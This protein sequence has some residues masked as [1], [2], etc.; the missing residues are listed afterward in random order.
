MKLLVRFEYPPADYVFSNLRDDISFG[1]FKQEVA[2]RK[3]ELDFGA[4]VG[5]GLG[6]DVIDLSECEDDTTLAEA[7]IKS[8]DTVVFFA[9]PGTKPEVSKPEARVKGKEKEESGDPDDEFKGISSS[10]IFP[11]LRA[12]LGHKKKRELA[13]LDKYIDLNITTILEEKG[14]G[15]VK[16]AVLKHVLKSNSLDVKEDDLFQAVLEWAERT[17]PKSATTAQVLTPLLPVLRLPC[18]SVQCWATL[19]A[20]SGLLDTSGNL[21]MFAYLA[22]RGSMDKFS[23]KDSKM[24]KLPEPL[25]HLNSIPRIPRA[26][27]WVFEPTGMG[28]NCVLSKH[29]RTVSATTGTNNKWASVRTTKWL[30]KGVHKIKFRIDGNANTFWIFLGVTESNQFNGN[31]YIGSGSSKGWT[32][33]NSG[34]LYPGSQYGPSATPAYKEG[35]VVVMTVDCNA[36]TVSY[37]L[38]GQD[39]GVAFQHINL[40][41]CPAVTLYNS[42]D[43]VTLI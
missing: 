38:N 34:R 36:K 2:T 27:R 14:L 26:G 24:P 39:L 35:D 3:G 41:V 5:A 28:S 25:K 7:G 42:G 8:L 11:K 32:S 15:S 17:K 30:D 16:T 9:S 23:D 10:N 19:G 37:A 29:N 12:A 6:R 13:L 33:A 21:A 1:Q 31:N 20:S 18:L 40:P 4:V 22:N 43:I